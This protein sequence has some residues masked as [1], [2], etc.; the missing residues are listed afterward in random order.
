MFACVIAV[1]P[2]IDVAINQSWRLNNRIV[3][4][5]TR[6]HRTLG[7]MQALFVETVNAF[8]FNAKHKSEYNDVRRAA[9]ARY[10]RNEIGFVE[11]VGIVKAWTEKHK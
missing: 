6:R 4:E 1:H 11:A 5:K 3:W 7:R 10:F 2:A 9:W 8:E